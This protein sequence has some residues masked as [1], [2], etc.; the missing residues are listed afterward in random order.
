MAAQVL[1]DACNLRAGGAVVAALQR[2]AFGF[3]LALR[4]EDG[5]LAFEPVDCAG[6]HACL[7]HAPL[8]TLH[9]RLPTLKATMK[10]RR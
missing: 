5:S 1:Q 10:T 2:L 7:E 3:I 4:A 9:H 8:W 6:T